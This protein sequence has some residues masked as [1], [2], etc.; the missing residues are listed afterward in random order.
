MQYHRNA[1]INIEQGQ[2]IKEGSE[3][4]RS[5]ANRFLVS[6]VTVAKWRKAEHLEDKSSRPKTIIMTFLGQNAGLL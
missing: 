2:I 3:S 1:K 4:T 5:L 6:H